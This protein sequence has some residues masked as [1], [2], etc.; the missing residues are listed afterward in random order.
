MTRRA[1]LKRGA[2]TVGGFFAGGRLVGTATAN[3]AGSFVAATRNLYLG[4]DLID[5]IT[6]RNTAARAGLLFTEIVTN[7]PFSRRAESIAAELT[8]AGP[9]PPHIIGM[10]EVSRF[11]FTP[12]D[13]DVEPTVVDHLALL[14]PALAN[15]G[16]PYGVAVANWNASITI[17]VEFENVP[18]TLRFRDR[19]VILARSDVETKNEMAGTYRAQ[20]PVPVTIEGR[21]RFVP[22]DFGWTRVDYDGCK[23]FNTHLDVTPGFRELQALELLDV[24]GSG[25]TLLLGDIN[26]DRADGGFNAYELLRFGGFDDAYVDVTGRHDPTCTFSE[27]LTGGTLNR[28]IDVVFTRGQFQPRTAI[29]TGLERN[30]V[31]TTDQPAIYPSDHAGVVV[32]F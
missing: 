28:Q 24:M 7:R 19:D 23:V 12:A 13:P 2:L 30:V 3:G 5:V 22:A 18:G 29:R 31:V 26:S 27:D 4:G 25:R 14:R 11:E 8:T 6:A 15:Q 16:V 21:L 10:Q 1:A 9:Q 17:P 20:V 32:G